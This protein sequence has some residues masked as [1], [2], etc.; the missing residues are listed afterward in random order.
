MMHKINYASYKTPSDFVRFEQGDNKVIIISGGG[1]VKKHGMMTARGYVPM[2]DCTEKP[3]CPQCLKGNEAKLKW[4]WI[5]YLPT[6]K[7][8]RVLD[9]G[10]SIGDAICK[11]AQEKGLEDLTG[12]QFNIIRTGINKETKYQV[13]FVSK[14][15]LSDEEVAFIEPYKKFLINKYFSTK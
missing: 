4:I 13:V 6:D 10:K 11:I 15:N 7:Q 2:G 8:V 14:V 9:V 5:A 12:Y 1:M 3:D